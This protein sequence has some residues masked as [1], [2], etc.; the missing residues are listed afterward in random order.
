MVGQGGGHGRLH[1]VLVGDVAGVGDAAAAGSGLGRMAVEL[2]AR[3][4]A[5]GPVAGPHGDGG[6]RGHQSLGQAEPDPPIPAGD[7][8]DVPVEPRHAGGRWPVAP[9]YTRRPTDTRTS[10]VRMPQNSKP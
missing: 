9:Q 5:A 3:R 8:G 2:L 7:D 1:L 10:V 6:A 4:R